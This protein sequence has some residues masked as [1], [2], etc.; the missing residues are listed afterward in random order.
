M[1]DVLITKQRHEDY[2]TIIKNLTYSNDNLDIENDELDL[3]IEKSSK[4][5][6]KKKN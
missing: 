5:K 6:T 2:Q 4:K 1:K 3:K